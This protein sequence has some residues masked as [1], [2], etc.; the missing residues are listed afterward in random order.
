MKRATARRVK[1]GKKGERAADLLFWFGDGHC[2]RHSAR[3]AADTEVSI[4]RTDSKRALGFNISSGPA[5]MDFVLN[6]DQVTELAAYL[7]LQAP[8]LLKPLGRKPAQISLA[9][10]ARVDPRSPR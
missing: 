9:A 10:I 2:A 8:R 5:Q 7:Q 3:V 4:G 1:S 6:R